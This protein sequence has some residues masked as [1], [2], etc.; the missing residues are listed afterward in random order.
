MREGELATIQCR[1]LDARDAEEL[2]VELWSCLEEY[3]IPTPRLRFFFGR[4][5]VD[6]EISTVDVSW[7]FVIMVR[8]SP[9]G[10]VVVGTDGVKA[11]RRTKRQ[12]LL[13]ARS[14]TA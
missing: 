13:I 4:D 5:W 3:E 9:F 7:D 11:A 14:A 10:A 12:M 6:V 8:L 2:V 1:H